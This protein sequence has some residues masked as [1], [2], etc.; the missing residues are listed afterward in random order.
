M[1][2]MRHGTRAANCS[3]C[4]QLHPRDTAEW[5]NGRA[6]KKNRFMMYLCRQ[7]MLVAMYDWF[8]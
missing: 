2:R 8:V 5:Q 4:V 3:E 6:F 1:E 7:V